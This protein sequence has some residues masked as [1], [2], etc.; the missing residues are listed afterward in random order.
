MK[1]LS[2][3][4]A[5]SLAFALT[6]GINVSAAGSTNTDNTEVTEEVV[7]E[8]AEEVKADGLTVEAVSVQE[9][10][11]TV[12]AVATTEAKAEIAKVLSIAGVKKA[13]VLFEVDL[14]STEKNVTKTVT[15][16]NDVTLDT[17]KKYVLAHKDDA[18]KITEYIS[19]EV[20]SA[21]SFKALFKSFSNYALIEVEE[22][23]NEGGDDT[24]GGN[25]TG[26]DTTGGNTTGGNTTGG[27]TTGG[28]TA[29]STT[30]APASTQPASP[31][32]GETVPVAGFAALIL[33]AGAA[34]CAKKA[35]F[36]N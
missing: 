28:D 18:G 35:Q 26:G 5:A 15:V 30:P 20:V 36:S 24:T 27:N 4:L 17:A 6:L 25:T 7:K 29:S 23:S 9:Y 12:A 19:V 33:L 1:K 3:V 14:G 11:A 10:E 13:T 34:V 21:K 22:T 32:T 16:P 31:Q 2:K 8:W